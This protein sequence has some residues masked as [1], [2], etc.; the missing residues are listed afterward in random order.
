MP[1]I[2]PGMTVIVMGLGRF[3]GGVG[4]ASYLLARGA[5]VTVTDLA[6]ADSL[7]DSITTLRQVKS[8]GTLEFE[9][10]THE[11]VSFED[12]ALVVVSPIERKK[13]RLRRRPKC[14]LPPPPQRTAYS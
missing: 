13:I 12:A 4:A 2:G 14:P 11:N 8:T 9:L 1:E 6:E 10:G 5:S 7:Q 3:G